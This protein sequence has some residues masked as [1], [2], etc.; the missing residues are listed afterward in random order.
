MSSTMKV[1][2]SC[3]V[4]RIVSTQPPW[5]TETST[6][7]VPGRIALRSS[8]RISLG[9]AAPWISTAPM[10]RSALAICRSRLWRLE[11]ISC[12]LAGRMSPRWR[13]RCTEMSS[14]TTCAP[15]PAAIFAAFSPTTP[16]PRITTLPGATPGPPGQPPP[17]PPPP[18]VELL[19][20][21]GAFLHGHAPGDFGHRRQQRQFARWQ[22]DRLVGD[23]HR[24]GSDVR[25]GE[26]F[27]RGEMEVGEDDLAGADARPFRLNRLLH[28]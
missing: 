7:T 22:L 20:I 17:P 8:R 27:A 14:S 28:F 6:I 23:A 25:A 18:A 5:S 26:L 4:G 9:A 21:L 1:G 19:Q 12:T 13:S 2:F 15:M 3:V 24:A 11:G 16:P 10:T